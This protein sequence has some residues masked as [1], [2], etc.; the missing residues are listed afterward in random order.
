MRHNGTNRVCWICDEQVECLPQFSLDGDGG[1]NMY[2]AAP[3]HH[4]IRPADEIL[5][6]QTVGEILSQ[7]NSAACVI[8]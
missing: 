4:E 5:A 1:V 3:G 2:A 8:S 6:K 7:N